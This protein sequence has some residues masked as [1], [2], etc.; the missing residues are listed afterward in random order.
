MKSSCSCTRFISTR[1]KKLGDGA[2]QQERAR[3]SLPRCD[4]AR[5]QSAQKYGTWTHEHVVSDRTMQSTGSLSGAWTAWLERLPDLRPSP[6]APKSSTPA[7]ETILQKPLNGGILMCI[8]PCER[9]PIRVLLLLERR[10]CAKRMRGAWWA[11][12]KMH[13]SIGEK[14]LQAERR[15]ALPNLRALDRQ[16]HRLI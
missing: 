16:R 12:C 2:A 13:I 11:T 6:A 4:P 5:W 1:Q 15:R 14:Q 3:T 8:L 7:L 10:V 9:P